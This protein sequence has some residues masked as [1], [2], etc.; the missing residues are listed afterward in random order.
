MLAEKIKTSKGQEE[1]KGAG[2]K[3]Q[4]AIKGINK[5]LISGK[6]STIE[7]LKEEISVQRIL[8]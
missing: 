1:E 7:Q 8:N 6:I 3:K 5:D 4:Y 2:K